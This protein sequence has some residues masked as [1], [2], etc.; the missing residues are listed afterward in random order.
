[1]SSPHHAHA[2]YSH[3]CTSLSASASASTPKS[4]SLGITLSH[5]AHQLLT[6][7]EISRS[8]T[9]PPPS[10]DVPSLSSSHSTHLPTFTIILTFFLNTPPTPTIS[11]TLKPPPSQ[12]RPPSSPAAAS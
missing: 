1:M 9:L 12:V 4:A 10:A 2:A 5:Q 3:A 6:L 8:S 11:C 7:P